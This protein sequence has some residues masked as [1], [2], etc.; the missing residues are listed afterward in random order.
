MQEFLNRF[1]MAATDGQRQVYYDEVQGDFSQGTYVLFS[2]IDMLPEVSEQVQANFL[3]LIAA[4]LGGKEALIEAL[5]NALDEV[6]DKYG[7]SKE[8][9]DSVVGEMTILVLAVVEASGGAGGIL[10]DPYFS[11]I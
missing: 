2:H 7:L 10:T 5:H 1:V 8:E 11:T 9:G 4:V 3:T 6:F